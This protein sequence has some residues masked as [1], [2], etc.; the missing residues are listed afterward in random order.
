ML[1]VAACG[2][3]RSTIPAGGEAATTVQ[4]ASPVRFAVVHAFDPNGADGYRP[5]SD[6]VAVNGM[7]YGTTTVGGTS[8]SKCSCG[9]VFSIDSTGHEKVIYRFA[10][11]KDGAYPEGGLVYFNGSFFGTTSVGG[12]DY[13]CPSPGN[14]TG[15]GT[16]F[17]IDSSGKE[18]IVYR[19]QG[20]TDGRDPVGDL[21]VYKN[22][23]YGVTTNGGDGNCQNGCGTVFTT[24][25]SGHVAVLY[26]FKGAG[27][28]DGENPM[29]SLTVLNG[30]LYGTTTAGGGSCK[31]WNLCGTVFTLTTSGAES[32]IHRFAKQDG[33]FPESTLVEVSGV[34]YGTTHYGGN[35]CI[36]SG[37]GTIYS[38]DPSGASERL[39]W[40]FGIDNDGQNPVGKLIV[41]NGAIYG[42]TQQGGDLNCGRQY[43][44]GTVFAFYPGKRLETPQH[45]F[46]NNDGSWPLTGL[47][48]FNDGLYGTANVDGKL[49][50]GSVFVVRP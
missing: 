41:R 30:K 32:V 26:R 34:L 13:A 15:C 22:V 9:A 19:F 27:A 7:L 31:A 4:A 2:G 45:R 18:R 23:L 8:Q 33:G 42:V 35:G 17:A 47:T 29:A 44:C 48:A 14:T 40:L 11:G 21:V 6:L 39:L 20:G 10:G 43:G 46:A 12:G 24:D 28:K 50:G 36:L 38:M 25:S 5:S 3:E 1:A 37:C 49:G 16:V